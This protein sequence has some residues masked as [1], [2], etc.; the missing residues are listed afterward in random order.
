M[1]GHRHGMIR[2]SARNERARK[3][4]CARERV[5]EREG[6]K[7]KG[8]K[9][10]SLKRQTEEMG[11]LMDGGEEHRRGKMSGQREKTDRTLKKKQYEIR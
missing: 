10:E 6:G 7:S 1:R 9:T 4:V 3:T 8:R 11:G 2:A 5:R